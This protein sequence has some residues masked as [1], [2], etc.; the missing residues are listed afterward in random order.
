M[1]VKS[2]ETGRRK[3]D[4][5][6]ASID[7]NT[8][9]DTI[10]YL[11]KFKTWVEKWRASAHQGLSRQTFAALLH[12]TSGFIQL[13]EYVI[14]VKG[15]DYLLTGFIQSDPLEGRF[16]WY[17]QLCGANYLISVLQF[18]QAEKP[19]AYSGSGKRWIFHIIN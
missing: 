10:G 3:K 6:R 9:N 1:N 4:Q 5:R 8:I 17:R 11:K 14:R 2:R 18:L 7:K 13:I 15:T 12:T 16:R 19:P